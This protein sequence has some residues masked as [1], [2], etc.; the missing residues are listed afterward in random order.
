M[1]PQHG[2]LIIAG[3]E[4]KVTPWL[5]RSRREDEVELWTPPAVAGW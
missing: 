5:E 1:I 4:G 3:T 2:F